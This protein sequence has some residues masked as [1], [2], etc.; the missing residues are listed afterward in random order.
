MRRWVIRIGVFLILGAIVNVAVAWGLALLFHANT[1]NPVKQG[2]KM[3]VA[4]RQCK[5]PFGPHTHWIARTLSRPGSLLVT[6]TCVSRPLPN[7][8]A[9]EDLLPPVPGIEADLDRF[10]AQGPQ[11]IGQPGFLYWDGR[12]WPMLSLSVHWPWFTTAWPNP[13]IESGISLR[14]VTFPRPWPYGVNDLH[15]LPLAPIWPGFAVN[16]LFYAAMH[17]L[18]VAGLV[19]ARWWSRIRRGLCPKCAYDLRGTR[20]SA[21]CPE[22]GAARPDA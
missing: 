5:E 4:H 22:C 11:A 1:T 21:A 16:M 13:P 10:E 20:E 17:W 2:W 6:V 7:A 19:A 9:L 3:D 12:G 14:N 15:A 18:L 8:R